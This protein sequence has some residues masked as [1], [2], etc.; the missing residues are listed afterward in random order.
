MKTLS[1]L[2][3]LPTPFMSQNPTKRR[4]FRTMVVASYVPRACKRPG[5]TLSDSSRRGWQTNERLQTIETHKKNASHVDELS[6]QDC[7]IRTSRNVQNRKSRR[8]TQ[9]R[10]RVPLPPL[11]THTHTTNKNL[12]RL[13][14]RV[15]RQSV[16][17]LRP[18]S[19]AYN[20]HIGG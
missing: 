17:G 4:K 18:M 12:A 7:H 16:S 2:S 19:A 9:I 13:K 20:F 3:L 15:L 14:L 8:N 6:T 10:P 1:R 5:D 11:N